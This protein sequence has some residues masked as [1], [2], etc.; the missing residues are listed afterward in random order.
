MKPTD[1]DRL[2]ITAATSGYFEN[3]G[4]TD[5]NEMDYE[6]N[7]DVFPNLVALLKNKSEHFAKTISKKVCTLQSTRLNYQPVQG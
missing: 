4:K 1:G 6:R 2:S 7:G 3:K 5:E